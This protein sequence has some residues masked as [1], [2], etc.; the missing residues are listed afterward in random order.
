MSP[1]RA[2]PGG[3]HPTKIPTIKS[4]SRPS[5]RSLDH[6]R[7]VLF[8][9]LGSLLLR[10]HFSTGWCHTLSS[11]DSGVRSGCHTSCKSH[12]FMNT[13]RVAGKERIHASRVTFK[14]KVSYVSSEIRSLVTIGGQDT[15]RVTWKIPARMFHDK[16]RGR[17]KIGRG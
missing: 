10:P 3:S 14:V 17:I 12:S 6:L 7:F 5:H 1:V 13:E 15:K 2:A 8:F 9:T 4:G 11:T 16:C